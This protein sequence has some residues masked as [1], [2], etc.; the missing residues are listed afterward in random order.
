VVVE[1][2][3]APE[4]RRERHV[5]DGEL[6][7][8]E[9]LLGEVGTAR[10]RD[11]ERRGA[12]VVQEE[13]PQVAA[14]HTEPLGEA[15]DSVFVERSVADEA[16]RARHDRRGSE[17]GGRSG[18]SFRPA[19]QARSKPGDFRRGRRREVTDVLVLRPG[20]RADGAAVNARRRDGDEKAAV[21]ARVARS[22]RPVEDAP[23]SIHAPRMLARGRPRRWP[24][25][26]LLVVHCVAVSP[27]SR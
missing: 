10:Q 17:P 8:V 3:H 7:F 12:E 15:L 23:L 18:R 14:R 26:D 4:A 25:T 27:P 24:E 13:T 1:G 11:L 16:Q 2:P 6:R 22:P 21:E 19:S 20:R 5:A 9:Q